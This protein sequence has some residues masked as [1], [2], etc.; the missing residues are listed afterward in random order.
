MAPVTGREESPEPG[1]RGLYERLFSESTVRVW[2]VIGG[3]ASAAAVLIALLSFM[4]SGSS[5]PPATSGAA[6]NGPTTDAL[7]ASV[8]AATTTMTTPTPT[9]VFTPT[10]PPQPA[11]SEAVLYLADRARPC[12]VAGSIQ[13]TGPAYINGTLYSHSIHQTPNGFDGTSFYVGRQARSF[14]ATV[15]PIDNGPFPQH[16][17]QFELVADGGATLFT[18][19]ALVAGQTETVNVPV[20]GVLNL[21]LIARTVGQTYGGQGTAGWGDARVTAADQIP[22]P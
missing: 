9:S 19:G 20:D 6:P 7:S 13:R 4:L 16:R 8:P 22:C 18:S 10:S 21:T 14:T 12:H 15:G 1:R 11:P 2:A 17:M 3:V 5:S